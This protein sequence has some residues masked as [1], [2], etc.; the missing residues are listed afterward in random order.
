[1]L[2]AQTKNILDTIRKLYRR[3]SKVTLYKVINKMHPSQMA[4]IYRY[5]NQSERENICSAS[6]QFTF[7]GNFVKISIINN[8]FLYAC[9]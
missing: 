7:D 6:Q 9:F 1:M 4:N 3:N 2:P 8:F 5:L